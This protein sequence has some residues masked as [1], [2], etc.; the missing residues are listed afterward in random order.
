M[1]RR[2]ILEF[3][4]GLRES[5]R[6][7]DYLWMAVWLLVIINLWFVIFLNQEHFSLWLLLVCIAMAGAGI[8][9]IKR[10]SSYPG[11]DARP[12]TEYDSQIADFMHEVRPLCE[13]IFQEE[14]LELTRPAIDGIRADFS[15]SL[16]WLWEESE[17][18]LAQV[19][20]IVAR[21]KLLTTPLDSLNETKTTLVQQLQNDS[22]LLSSV[23]RDMH[24]SKEN[25]YLDLDEFLENQVYTLKN[26]MDKEKEVFYDYVN[27]LLSRLSKNRDD[28]DVDE[29][30]DLEKLGQQFR[31]ILE[32]ALEARQMAFQDSVIRELENFSADIVGKMQK[33][34]NQMLNLFQDIVDVL[35]RMKQE[36]WD[37]TNMSMRQLNECL[38]V[39]DGIREKS[40]EIML[41]LAWQDILVE[42]RWQDM[43]ERLFAVRERVKANVE[44]YLV[45]FISN[46][47][48]EELPGF[49]SMAHSMENVVLYKAVIDAEMIY[50]LYKGDKLLNI[51]EDGVYSLL[52]FV[53][54]V[55]AVAGKSIR[56]TEEGI[57]TLKNMK[58]EIK[59]GEHQGSFDRVKAAVG[60]YCPEASP[61]LRD[62]YPRGFYAFCNYP[63]IKQKPD[64]LNQAA[65]SVFLEATRNHNYEEEVFL[66]VGLLLVIHQVR[67]KYIHPLKN[68]PLELES[69]DDLEA[70]RNAA[71]KSMSIMLTID[72]RGLAKLSFK[73]K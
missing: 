55:E 45:S 66:L 23:V 6:K 56:L 39:T 61:Y 51:I 47:I 37:A 3:I 44:E 4:A 67:N 9:F 70:V 31:V 63:Y 11:P 10:F 46:R 13:Q 29:Y 73:G 5:I 57:R 14:I 50:Q 60:E 32:K 7:N 48:S 16:A 68:V 27:R 2:V 59:S 18:Y 26:E 69:F 20:S 53:K 49:A 65:W 38:Y 24:H 19:E 52:Q 72:F 17:D 33:N 1:L 64:N 21:L 8:W 40:S 54:P 58:N 25:N 71:L 22:E 34:T 28:I 30:F 35:E 42:K 62:V 43:G 15:T 36:N 12:A 41:T